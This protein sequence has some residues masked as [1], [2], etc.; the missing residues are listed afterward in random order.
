MH[1]KIAG[2]EYALPTRTLST[3]ELSSLFPEW[4]VEKIDQKTGIHCRHLSAPDECASDLGYSAAEKLFTSGVCRREEIDYLLFCSQ[5]ADYLL[6]ATAC[7][8]QD[9]LALPTCA[10]A[11][12]INLGCSGFV[13]GL[14]LAEGLIV[15]GQATNVLLITA[16]TYSKYIRE[17]DKASR[18]VFGDGAAATLIRSSDAGPTIGPF[19]YGT[20]GSG[21]KRIIV[22]DSGARKCRTI[23]QP[24]SANKAPEYLYMDGPSVFSFVVKMI[25]GLVTRVLAKAG[26]KKEE[27]D[28][29]VFHQA[30][31]YL[32]EEISMMLGLP[33]DKV[34]ITLKDCANTVSSTIPIALKHAIQEG[35]LKAGD[36]VMLI[37]FGVGFSWAAAIVRW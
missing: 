22:L 8:L 3:E 9:R 32:L 28:L 14:G 26:L 12:D 29:F 34:Q 4:S 5:S 15:A 17:D 1:G 33:R 30:N 20:D 11:L 6:P 25:P 27:V 21:A 18:T 23:R 31:Q 16:D 19:E 7:L 2:I 37:G 36:C 24:G 35:K 13:Y 10:G